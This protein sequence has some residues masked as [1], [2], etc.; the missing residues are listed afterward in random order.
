MTLQQMPSSS[1]LLA[2]KGT[3]APLGLR[4]PQGSSDDTL[5]TLDSKGEAGAEPPESGAASL[6]K[7]GPV[8][9]D[10]V[11][12]IDGG[13]PE[14][15]VE[16]PPPPASL[17]PFSLR[18]ERREPG[19][20]WELVSTEIFERMAGL[21]KEPS[22]P[23]PSAEGAETEVEARAPEPQVPESD[24]SETEAEDAPQAAT[25]TEATEASEA[26]AAQDDETTPLESAPVE[27]AEVA[28]ND[29]E[30][31]AKTE[32]APLEETAP[33][34]SIGPSIEPSPAPSTAP[35]EAPA[36]A[37]PIAKSE[38]PGRIAPQVASAP[39]ADPTWRIGEGPVSSTGPAATGRWI[40]L[41][42]AACVL[43][44]GIGWWSYST[45]APQ[46]VAPPPAAG[47]EAAKSASAPSEAPLDQAAPSVTP[48]APAPATGIEQEAAVQPSPPAE[49]AAPETAVAAP[50]TAEAGPSVDLVRIEPDGDAVIAGR[51]APNSELIVLDNGL[52]IGTVTADAFGEW[53]FVPDQPLSDGRH[54]F[55][56]V[57]KSVQGTVAVP[58]GK[59][60]DGDAP[61]EDS[62]DAG[63]SP[64]QAAPKPEEGAALRI[65]DGGEATP[66]P[67]R[68]PQDATELRV[69]IPLRK[70]D[71]EPKRTGARQTGEGKAP[72]TTTGTTTGTAPGTAAGAGDDLGFQT[73]NSDFVVQLASVKTRDG[74][75][76]EWAKLQ[77]R[78]P[79]VLHGMNLNLDEAKLSQKGKVVRVRTGP[80]PDLNEAVNFCQRLR[81]GQQDCLVV[82]TNVRNLTLVE[83]RR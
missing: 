28:M 39:V 19:E 65:E 70:P 82:R 41:G 47:G 66:V 68:K 34:S 76:Q 11:P 40:L 36:P 78:F 33:E 81:A 26:V 67:S 29:S 72:G 62:P 3:A 1:G 30:A 77:S 15:A 37:Q 35:P 27:P 8:Q 57:V 32:D 31:A 20:T 49:P 16:D 83:S 6:E 55:G 5:E 2:R 24:A 23:A 44:A 43:I 59:A 4:R 50:G 54:E 42:V 53:V 63:E 71:T 74:A 9:L 7:L 13:A 21:V 69:P 18:R 73:P 79:E 60:A 25:E 52:P 38:E 64:A 75:R 56:L 14:T 51:A 61:A 80:F 45:Q 22:A 10:L 12:D 46:P 48:Q 17:L 58:A